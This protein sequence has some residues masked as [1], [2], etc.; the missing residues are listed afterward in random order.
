MTRPQHTCTWRA[1]AVA[2]V[3]LPVLAAATP[4]RAEGEVSLGKFENWEA[5]TY[6][7]PESKVCY[8]FGAPAKT[9]SSRKAKRSDI[10]FMV[11]HWPGR[12]V[13]GQPSTMIGYQF[14]DGVDVTLTVGDKTFIL[15]PVGEL[16]WA[17]KTETE[18]AIV[19]AMKGGKTMTVKGISQRGT[20]TADTY[21]LGGFTAALGAIDSA[22]K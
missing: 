16:A 15:Y 21:S 4:A 18:R 9:Q 14:K 11:T 1:L 20:E 2:A 6:D 10:Y 8:V 5:F 12:K 7:T 13:R 22:C 17:D 3:L 19:A